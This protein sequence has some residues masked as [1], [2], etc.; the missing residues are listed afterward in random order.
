MTATITIQDLLK[1]I[2]YLLGIGVL[3][4][5]IILIKNVTIVFQARRL[6]EKNEE[7]MDR[8]LKQLPGYSENI[9]F[10]SEETKAL[11][12]ESYLQK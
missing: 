5:L 9:N 12:G 2:L 7:E 1:L 4:Y 10:I 8:V 3:G 6:A 11:I